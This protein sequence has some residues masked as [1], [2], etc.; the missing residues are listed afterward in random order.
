M[1]THFRELAAAI[2]LY[3]LITPQN[4]WAQSPAP[5]EPWVHVEL[6]AGN[7]GLNHPEAARDPNLKGG[8]PDQYRVLEETLDDLV[9]AHGKS[10]VFYVND[11]DAA[12]ADYAALTLDEYR[13]RQGYD[14]VKIKTWVAD[15][16]TDDP[17]LAG[18]IHLKNPDSDMVSGSALRARVSAIANRSRT[19]LEITSSYHEALHHL[20][21]QYPK[22]NA[23]FLGDGKP[24][25]YPTGVRSNRSTLILR[26]PPAEAPQGIVRCAI[27][28]FRKFSRSREPMRLRIY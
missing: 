12:A 24:Y 23:N 27:E 1:R 20:R 18:S 4:A 13:K 22:L 14:Q 25:Y 6:G 19:G 7:Y 15:F 3:A 2:F 17:P 5:R 8:S 16:L 10:V 11:R 9:K 28:A 21:E 26:I